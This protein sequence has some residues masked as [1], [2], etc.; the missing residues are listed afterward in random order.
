MPMSPLH[1]S[2]L[3]KSSI[4]RQIVN[5]E[6]FGVLNTHFE[7][8]KPNINWQMNG[9]I[10]MMHKWNSMEGLLHSVFQCAEIK[11]DCTYFWMV[12]MKMC[13]ANGCD[14]NRQS[15]ETF[16]ILHVTFAY[17]LTSWH[18]HSHRQ[19]PTTSPSSM[20]YTSSFNS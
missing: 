1:H 10:T 13:K 14:E 16:K 7:A 18:A 9:S 3:K 11:N 15:E 8:K 2:R 12:I 4:R 5:P 19:H 6:W 17:T 20:W